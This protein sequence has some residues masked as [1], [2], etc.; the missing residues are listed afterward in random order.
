[1]YISK[2]IF[3]VILICTFSYG[4][5]QNSKSDSIPTPKTERYGLRVGVDAYRLVLSVINDNY[6]GLE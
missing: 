3:S 5:A 6:K 1:M 2:C 4:K